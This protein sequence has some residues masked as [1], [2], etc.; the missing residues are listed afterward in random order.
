MSALNSTWHYNNALMDGAM[1]QIIYS[2]H[3]LGGSS[4]F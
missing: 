3:I 1:L 2:L 4:F